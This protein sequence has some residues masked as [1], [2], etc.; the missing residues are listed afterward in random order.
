[1]LFKIGLGNEKGKTGEAPFFGSFS[2]VFMNVS[3]ATNFR[4]KPGRS[5]PW[6]PENHHAMDSGRGKPRI[7]ERETVVR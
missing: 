5:V 6:K 1:L 7:L 2:R 4:K 3:Y